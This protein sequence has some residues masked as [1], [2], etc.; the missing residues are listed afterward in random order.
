MKALNPGR[1]TTLVVGALLAGL[2]FGWTAEMAD[3]ET[4]ELVTFYPTTPGDSTLD[5]LNVMNSLG[6]GTDSPDT[7][8]HLLGDPSENT[9]VLFLSGSG[10][11]IFVGIDVADPA[12]ADPKAPLQISGDHPS[13]VRVDIDN[14]GVGQSALVLRD[15]DSGVSS[16]SNR[17]L[18]AR[19]DGTHPWGAA[20]RLTNIV[21]NAVVGRYMI[22][23]TGDH[24]FGG[25]DGDVHDEPNFTIDTDGKA[26]LSG[27][28]VLEQNTTDKDTGCI[29]KGSYRFIHNYGGDSNIFVGMS[30]GN[31]VLDADGTS[32]DALFNT[33]L[34]TEALDNLNQGYSNTAVGYRA[35][36]STRDGNDN[37]AVGLQAG[38]YNSD[39]E[40]NVAIGHS[41]LHENRSGDGNVG[42]GKS[43]LYYTRGQSNTAVGMQALSG[44]GTDAANV[45]GDNNSAFG[46]L[47][48]NDV[49]TGN[50]NVAMGSHALYA[51][52]TGNY[53][54]ALGYSAGWSTTTG[55]SNVFI[56]YYA[57]Y[58]AGATDSNKLYIENSSSSNPLIYGDFTDNSEFVTVN[59]NFG[60]K[61]STF[62]TGAKGVLGIFNGTTPSTSPVNMVQLYVQP[63]VQGT[64]SASKSEL[65]VRDQ[66]GN[67]TTLSPH[68]FSRIPQGPSEPMAWAFYS[69]R[70]KTAINVDMLKAVRWI[71][72]LSGEELV[73]LV[74]LATGKTLAPSTA[75]DRVSALEQR[76][77]KHVE[78]L[79]AQNRTLQRRLE[80]LER[81]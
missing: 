46:Y 10:G 52:S 68:N 33:A 32:P 69:E 80:A 29:Y 55:S 47:A 45:T 60:I 38:F 59:G 2:V 50:R 56:G 15:I 58:N 6:V 43:A 57:G 78:V 12:T 41:A 42:V 37:T 75:Q 5:N 53:N 18:V 30:A 70:G 31:F 16:L 9:E 1:F 66:A 77:L 62:G 81:R 26:T 3:A 21:N 27:N 36:G 65:F 64:P 13:S 71:E 76:L 79:K 34:G 23:E 19:L 25:A 63:V 24:V 61:T 8:F 28:L 7:L 49:T 39:G 4:I 20:L 72:A 51:T 11:K 74:D 54:T 14:E 22:S 67:V 35:L 44:D 73:H 48:M 40:R 17:A